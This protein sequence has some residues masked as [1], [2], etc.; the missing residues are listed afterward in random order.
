MVIGHKK[1]WELLRRKFEQG[2]LSHAYMFIGPGEIGKKTFALEFVK[3]INSTDKEAQE[4]NSKLID[5]GQHPDV[6]M[7]AP[8]EESE[9]QI[10]Q[11]R[12]VQQ[13]LSLKPYYSQFK[14]V[15]IDQADKMNQEAQSCFLK[16]LEEPKGNTILIL[17][18]ARPD[19]MLSTI[20]SRAQA[21]KFFNVKKAE[22]KDYLATIG[23]EEKKAELISFISEGK[24]GRAIKLAKDETI[25][26]ADKKLLKEAVSACQADLA[27]KFAYIKALPEENYLGA[28]EAMKNYF[29]YVLFSRI[30][31][32]G[33]F[34]E[35]YFPVIGEKFKVIP[36]SKVKQ[37]IQL[38]ETID[39]RILTT[40]INKK[41]ALEVLLLEI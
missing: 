6:L 10:A 24:L 39:F 5:Q 31:I 38:I 36:V 14:A 25:M 13:F 22:I 41:L 28:L 34:G 1:Q 29:R 23:I 19:M 9:I 21:V 27:T 32:N 16:T 40:N 30:G 4:R 2:Q 3:L 20:S 26:E 15:I 37:I 33:Y 11:I 8:K 18:T 7:V 35:G 17:V 12:E